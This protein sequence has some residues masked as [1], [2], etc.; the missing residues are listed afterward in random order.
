MISLARFGTEEEAL[1]I[2]NNSR[3]GLASYFYINNSAQCWWV[4]KKLQTAWIDN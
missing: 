1:N 4:G 2:A 3:T